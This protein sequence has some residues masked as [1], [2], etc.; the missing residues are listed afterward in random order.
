MVFCVFVRDLILSE[1]VS[2]VNPIWTGCV[3]VFHSLAMSTFK[4]GGKLVVHSLPSFSV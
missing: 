2:N 1:G 3:S 4:V